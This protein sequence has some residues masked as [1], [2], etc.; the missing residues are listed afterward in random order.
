MG[1]NFNFVKKW[2]KETRKPA[3]IFDFLFT[4]ES[5]GAH[6]CGCCYLSINLCAFWCFCLASSRAFFVCRLKYMISFQQKWEW[7]SK[8]NQHFGCWI[9]LALPNK[10]EFLAWETPAECRAS[11]WDV[12]RQWWQKYVVPTAA[13]TKSSN[14]YIFALVHSILI[15]VVFVTSGFAVVI[16]VDTRHSSIAMAVPRVWHTTFYRFESASILQ[17]PGD[18]TSLSRDKYT[19]RVIAARNSF[20][21]LS[22]HV[23]PFHNT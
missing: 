6:G 5:Y 9:H 14:S 13:N 17:V 11:E 18:G 12:C 22:T 19:I 10:F 15:F 1:D 20:C 7:K 16:G 23:S 2:K 21:I 3:K 4:L 8:T